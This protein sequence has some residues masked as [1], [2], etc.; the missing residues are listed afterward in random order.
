MVVLVLDFSVFVGVWGGVH[1][2]A[3]SYVCSTLDHVL[4][5]QKVAGGIIASHLRAQITPRPLLA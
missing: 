3:C 5:V 2:F 4:G 1:L